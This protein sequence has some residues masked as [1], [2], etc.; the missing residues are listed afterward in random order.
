MGVRIRSHESKR[1]HRLWAALTVGLSLL[2]LAACSQTPA[3]TN[4]QKAGGEVVF[5]NWSDFTPETMLKNFEQETGIKVKFSTF[6]SNE[7]VLA[8]L[9]AGGL[10]NYDLI[11][12]SDYTVDILRKQGMLEEIDKAN[13]PNFK[14]LIPAFLDQAFDPGNKYS[15]PYM[16]GNVII[17]YNKDTVKKPITG[18]ADLWDPEFVNNLVVLDDQRTLIGIAN[19]MQGKSMNDT[20]PAVLKKSLD[21]LLALKPN[22][23]AFDSDSPKN[24]LINGEVK[25]GIVWGAEAAL[26]RK[27]N[28]SIVTVNP[29]EGMQ[30]WIDNLVIPKGAPHKQNAEAFINFMLEGKNSVELTKAFPYMLPNSAGLELTDDSIKNDPAVYPPEEDMKKGEY[31]IDVGDATTELDRIWSQFKQ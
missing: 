6:S 27:D 26:A 14:N 17:A 28:P 1:Q 18:Y 25:A 3:A 30:L 21:F 5:S 31:F 15:I 20:D 29:K 24:M 16:A 10:G 22:I 2:L 4:G 19:K 8:K 12:V 23:K 9:S 11:V 13:I 7:E